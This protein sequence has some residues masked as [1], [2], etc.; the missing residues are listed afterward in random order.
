MKKTYCFIF[1][2]GGSKGL[3]KKNILSIAGI[4]LLVHSIKLAKSLSEINSIYVSTD[5]EEIANVAYKENVEVI[6][7]PNEL[8]QD[9]TPEWLAWQHAI[10]YVEEK[11]G[12]FDCFL[13][14][15]TTAPLR[16]E[17]DIKKCLEALKPNVDLV[18]TMSK[19]N[20]SPWFN[21]VTADNSSK[22]DLVIKNPGINPKKLE[23]K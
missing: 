11:E 14:L 23:K 12:S 17:E 13:S 19:A 7:R 22:V 6:K 3:P 5:C 10:K 2:R 16:I 9:N 15:P 1:A 18:L 4:P 21:M 8:A 20:R